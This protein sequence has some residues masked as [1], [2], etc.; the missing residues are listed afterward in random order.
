[1]FKEQLRLCDWIDSG[2]RWSRAKYYMIDWSGTEWNE[3]KFIFHYLDILG[4]SGTRFPFHYLWIERSG[5]NY[6][7][8]IFLIIYK[9][10]NNYNKTWFCKWIIFFV[11]VD[12]PLILK[13][14][15]TLKLD[16]SMRLKIRQNYTNDH[17]S[18]LFVTF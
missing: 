13:H 9:I 16:Y 4:W 14:D 2:M 18:Y 12:E 5:M 17:L 7:I 3:T 15:K 6:N 8:F 1:M 11:N 10:K